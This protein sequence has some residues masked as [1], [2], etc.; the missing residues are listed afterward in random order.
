MDPSLV[1]RS[2]SLSRRINHI[3]SVNKQ[4]GFTM[5]NETILHLLDCYLSPFSYLF[6]PLARIGRQR[7]SS[8]L[9]SLNGLDK[10]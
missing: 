5:I 2:L 7:R 6:L 8:R 1:E 10:M 9:M 4:F 3:L